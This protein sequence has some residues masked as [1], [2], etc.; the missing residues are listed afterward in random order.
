MLGLFRQQ[1]L[2]IATSLFVAGVLV[3]T[4]GPTIAGTRGALRRPRATE[5]AWGAILVAESFYCFAAWASLTDPDTLYYC[6]N[7][8][9]LTSLT[10]LAL[11]TPIAGL[12][13]LVI[14]RRRARPAV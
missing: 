10:A 11:A 6:V 9:A 12:A 14:A 13:W 2:A 5:W 1:G 3:P 7:E 8:R 4:I